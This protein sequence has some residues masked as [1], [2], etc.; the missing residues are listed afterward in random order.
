M[1]EKMGMNMCKCPHH[2]MLPLLVIAF[3]A[4]FLLGQWNI[5]T[6]AAVNTLWPLIVIAVGIMKLMGKKCKCCMN[7]MK[8]NM[9]SGTNSNMGMK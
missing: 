6:M 4:V 7:A 2:S 5:L 3:G 9:G 8:M 1:N